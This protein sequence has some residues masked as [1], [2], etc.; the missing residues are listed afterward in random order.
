[1]QTAKV[2]AVRHPANDWN[3]ADSA[4]D[5]SDTGRYVNEGAPHGTSPNNQG[6]A[7]FIVV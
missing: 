3:L 1:M 5:I 7:C 4:H 6:N 2:Q